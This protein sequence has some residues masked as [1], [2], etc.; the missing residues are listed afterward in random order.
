MVKDWPFEEFK[1]SCNAAIVLYMVVPM[2]AN[3]LPEEFKFTSD[4]LSVLKINPNHKP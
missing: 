1:F 3:P 2:N 4:I